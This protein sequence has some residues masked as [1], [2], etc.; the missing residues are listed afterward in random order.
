MKCEAIADGICEQAKYEITLGKQKIKV[1][2][3]HK[4]MWKGLSYS[5]SRVII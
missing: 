3:K 4:D 2:E 5:K 1:C